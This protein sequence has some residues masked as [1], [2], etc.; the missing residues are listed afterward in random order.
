MPSKVHWK[1]WKRYKRSLFIIKVPFHG[2]T[3]LFRFLKIIERWKVIRITSVEKG[4]GYG[5]PRDMK[6]K[7]F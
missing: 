7:V 1:C 5:T 4:D 3:P 2:A 6:L